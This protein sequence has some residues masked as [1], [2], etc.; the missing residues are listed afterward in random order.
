MIREEQVDRR[1]QGGGFELIGLGAG[2]RL[3]G[4]GAAAFAGLVTTALA[5]RLLGPGSYGILAFAF[6]AAALAAG[7]GRLGLEPAVARSIAIRH[8]GDDRPGMVRV[9]RG[10]LSLVA[11]TGLVGTA[12]TLIV[13]EA[14]S[15]GLGHGTR[16]VLGGLLGILLYGS[17]VS[18]VGAAL[19]RG[20]GRVM[21]MELSLLVPALAK[22]AAVGLLT[23]LDVTDIRW[24]AAGYAAGAAAGIVAAS[25]VMKVV[26]GRGRVLLYDS[27]AAHEVL[28]DSLPFAVA[29]LSVIVISRLDVVVLGLTATGAEVGVYEPTLKLVEQAMLLVPFLFIAQ[30][31]PVASRTFAAGNEA[32]FRQL[33]VD[34]SKLVVVLATPAVIVLTA[35]PE[36]L[37]HML[38]GAAFPASGLI[39][40]LLLPG[41]IVNLGL[42]LNSS[43]L[44]AVGDR[45]ALAATGLIATAAMV[46]LAVALVPA[47][48][49]EGAAA[50]T[51]GTYV[52]L[53]LAVSIALY[54]AAGAHPLRRDLVLTILTWA[55]PVA[56]G[57]AI[58]ASSQE[59]SGWQ[60]IGLALALSLIWTAV[61]FAL[62]VLRR[63]EIMRLLPQR[64]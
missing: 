38:Y 47:F 43:A 25:R 21:L 29:G 57:L 20:T 36:A 51:S 5:V 7:I 53:N 64:G 31:L 44:S 37:L 1:R 62:R 63:D 26:L 35:F 4:A 17:N 12:V 48:G 13:V 56:G 19:A 8:D 39:V 3:V 33:Y 10:A 42:G 34:V 45:R 46:M 22:L 28:R 23:A 49:A 59:V 32:V 15:H 60:A 2:A 24:V 9:T 27:G 54:R 50:A 30:F 16:L 11:A 6:S 18:A 55:G 61:L 40:W 14:A 58:R 52:I 41:F